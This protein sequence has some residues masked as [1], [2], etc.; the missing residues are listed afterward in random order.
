M[1]DSNDPRAAQI[2]ESRRRV[3][4]EPTSA[5]HYAGKEHDHYGV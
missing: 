2:A 3:L 4:T 5:N 1:P